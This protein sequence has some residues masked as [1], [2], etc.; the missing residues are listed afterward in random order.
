MN[1]GDGVWASV[2]TEGAAIGHACSCLTV[3]NLIRLGNTKVLK[4]YNCQYFRKAAINVTRITTGYDP[5][6][7]QPIYG[8]R[9]LDFVFD[10]GIDKFDLAEFFEEETPVRISTL[11]TPTMIR[12]RLVT[13]FGDDDQFTEEMGK[14]MLEVMLEDL[15]NN[16]YTCIANTHM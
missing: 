11:A 16:R 2:C 7:K 5:P 15:R 4:K 3:M 13:L 8:E 10:M 12:D 9:A 14:K 6:T 1:G